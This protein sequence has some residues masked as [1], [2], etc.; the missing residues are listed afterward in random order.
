M[1]N[2]LKNNTEGF[3]VLAKSRLVVKFSLIMSLMV[4]LVIF[5]SGLYNYNKNVDLILHNLQNQLKLAANTIAIAIDGDKYEK[6]EGQKSVNTIDYRRIKAT[7][8]HFLSNNKYLEFDDDNIYTFRRI[9]DE[10]LEFTVMVD[11]QYVGEKYKI[12]EEM[13]PVLEK[14]ISNYTG[15]YEDKSGTW[16]SA[17]APILNSHGKVTGIVEVDF[18]N[19]V[20]LV[21][22]KNEIYS[23]LLFSIAGIVIAIIVAIL[24]SR[25]ISRPITNV[26]N[27]AIKLSKGDFD[28]TVKVST[29]DELGL[30]AKAFNYMVSEIKEKEYIQ[31]K[32]QELKMA[33]DHCSAIN[34]SLDEANYFKSELMNIASH[35]L[36]NVLQLI[37]VYSQS[38]LT[39]KEQH[40]HVY[41]NAGKIEGASKRMLGLIRELLNTT[42]AEI[43]QIEL[44]KSVIDVG[45]LAQYVV[46]NNKGLAYKKNQKLECFV[47]DGCMANVDENRVYEVMDNLVNNAIKYSPDNKEV[48]VSVKQIVDNTTNNKKVRFEVRDMGP[49]L[50]EDDKINLFRKFTK[51]SAKPTGGETSTGL[52]LYIVKKFVDLHQGKI[53]AESEGEGKG[54]T[55]FAE[56]EVN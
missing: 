5:I 4:F 25:L 54:S 1:T 15:L 41:R 31:K 45:R 27:A 2:K 43:G 56:F 50:N 46:S 32:N 28:V 52:G 6:L 29:N 22:V 33:Y 37:M 18:R 55:F 48:H 12:R 30:L 19:N 42:N 40:P 26:T 20:Y 3:K 23:I 38:T 21:A 24:L 10:Y 36:K 17:Y 16:I 53:W 35:D 8:K 51:L 11:D 39:I 44:K 13:I 14:G 34:Q 47:E 49:G 7:L 9:D